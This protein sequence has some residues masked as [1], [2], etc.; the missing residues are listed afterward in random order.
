MSSPRAGTSPVV[1][2]LVGDMKEFWQLRLAERLLGIVL[3]AFTAFW[4]FIGGLIVLFDRVGATSGY[5]TRAWVVSITGF[6]I[7]ILVGLAYGGG[8]LRAFTHVSRSSGGSFVRFTAAALAATVVALW[9]L[10]VVLDT[11]L[12]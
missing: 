11:T 5:G 1:R 4:T 9:L 10:A 8:L 2:R 6:A 12:S 7:S 3:A